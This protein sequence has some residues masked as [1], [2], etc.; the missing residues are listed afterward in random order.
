MSGRSAARLR[1]VLLLAPLLLF[2]GVFF[3]WPLVTVLAAAI[4]NESVAA[5][6]PATARAI[7]GWDDIGLPGPEVQ[8][9]L[10]ADLRETD[11]RTLGVAVGKL[12][13]TAPGF[14]SLISATSQ[15][16]REAE[17][18]APPALSGIDPRWEDPATWGTIRAALQPYTDRNLLAAFDL[19]RDEAGRIAPLPPEASANRVI[20]WRTLTISGTITL[21]CLVLGLPYALIAASAT[22]WR[23]NAMLIAVLLPLW[24][25]LLVRTAAW[26]IVLQDNGVVNDVLRAL[27]LIEAPLPLIF[28]RL[29]V[30]IA[31]THVLLPFMVLPIYTV[32]LTIPRTLMPAAASLGAAP[33]TAFR[34]VLLPLAMPGILSGVLLVFM[35]AIGYYIT[36]ALLGGPGDQMISGTIAFYALETAN[37]GMAGA[38]GLILLAATLILYA[39]YG[40]FSRTASPFG[41]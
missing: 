24:T 37:W 3:V 12:N 7:S 34:R 18:G 35:V 22:G 9:A 10:L 32:L 16:A 14:R 28:N 21:C 40:R 1:A 17:D 4:R 29:G 8:A 30:V 19:G 23:R 41:A 15:A 38:L 2:L 39:L 13:S 31:M 11:R 27:G 26:Y 20:L 25:S 36:P 5:A 33:W 6:F